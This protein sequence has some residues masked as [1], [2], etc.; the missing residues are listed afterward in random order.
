MAWREWGSV[1]HC[2]TARVEC[3]YIIGIDGSSTR[4]GTIGPTRL[5]SDIYMN[6]YMEHD[7]EDIGQMRLPLATTAM[8]LG[9]GG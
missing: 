7:V 5:Q 8:D 2:E 6:P 3:C 9:G 4:F 1:S